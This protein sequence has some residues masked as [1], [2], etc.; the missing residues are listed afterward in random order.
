MVHHKSIE[1]QDLKLQA[2][3]KRAQN[4]KHAN[5]FNWINSF[6]INSNMIPS[7]MDLKLKI[8]FKLIQYSIRAGSLQVLYLQIK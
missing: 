1:I 2:Q 3:M 5:P 6:E 8:P 7:L 4:A